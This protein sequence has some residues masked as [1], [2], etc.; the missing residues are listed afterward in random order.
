MKTF[1]N[2]KQSK[3]SAFTLVETV[4]AITLFTIASLGIM[5]MIES[6]KM[7]KGQ[8]DKYLYFNKFDYGVN[9]TFLDILNAIEEASPAYVVESDTVWGMRGDEFKNTSVLPRLTGGGTSN[10]FKT[11]YYD[12]DKANLSSR[13]YKTLVNNIL[14]NFSGICSLKT[15]RTDGDLEL[16]CGGN[17][18]SLKYEVNGN[19]YLDSN[20]WIKGKNINPKHVPK[21]TLIYRD[22][23]IISHAVNTVNYDFSLDKVYALRQEIS[24]SKFNTI[25]N[26]LI[27][28]SNAKMTKETLNSPPYGL[29]STDD[30]FVPYFWEAFSSPSLPLDLKCSLAGGTTCSNL[31]TYWQSMGGSANSALAIMR[32]VK[33][34]L[35]NDKSLLVDGFNNEIF[36]YPLLKSC[37]LNNI[38][39]C[40]ISSPPLPQNEYFKLGTMTTTAPYVSA[41]FIAP[42]SDKSISAPQYG[43]MLIA[44]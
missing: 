16:N 44:Y 2:K 13:N 27:A 31:S 32:V 43:R 26:A 41:I 22:V 42:F 8:Q 21:V 29:N 11:L 18:R 6:Q 14:S 5:R 35:S 38:A 19:T 10:D 17:I 3:R 37:A 4:F 39:S 24:A 9:K 15:Q 12:I 36:I 23:H 40:T 7:D 28:F 30:T 34:L 25:R 33:N 20:T 1:M